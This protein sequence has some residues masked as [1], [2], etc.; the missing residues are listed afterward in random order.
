MLRMKKTVWVNLAIAL[1]VVGGAVVAQGQAPGGGMSF[2]GSGR[3]LVVISGRV[4]C[5]PCSLED[6]QKAQPNEYHL[7]QLAYQQN[8][9]V[10]KMTTVNEKVMFDSLAWPPRLAVRGPEHLLKKLSDE[11]NLFKEMTITGLLHNTRTL[12]VF[13]VA[14]KG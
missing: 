3:S 14:V 2:G 8:Q 6:A 10:M 1:M 4:M 7:Y 9:L 13:D 5:A 11:E 12:D